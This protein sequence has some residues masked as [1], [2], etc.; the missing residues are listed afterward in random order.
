MKVFER[1][2]RIALVRY[3]VE[4]N[5]LPDG[6]HGFRSMRS[7]LPQ[8]LSYWDTILGELEQG[9]GVDVIYTDSV[10]VET[11]VLLHKLRE[12]QQAVVVD[13]RVS[14]LCSVQYSS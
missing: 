9:H 2:V 11:G 1:V 10:K 12:L 14:S 8:L 7:T 6:Q 4:N 3:L 5:F 13:G